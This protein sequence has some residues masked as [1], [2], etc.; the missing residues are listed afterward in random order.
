MYVEVFFILLETFHQHT[1][2]LLLKDGRPSQV[3]AAP[4]M[5]TK[6]HPEKQGYPSHCEPSQPSGAWGKIKPPYFK[7]L[8]SGAIYYISKC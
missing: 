2:Y 6:T 3:P 1:R 4:A 8:S 5:L 7:L